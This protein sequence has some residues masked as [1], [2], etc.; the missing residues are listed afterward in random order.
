MCHPVVYPLKDDSRRKSLSFGLMLSCFRYKISCWKRMN[1]RVECFTFGNDR[2][3]KKATTTSLNF[4]IEA[5]KLE[6]SRKVWNPT[7]SVRGGQVHI[8]TS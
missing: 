1:P 8:S 6:H 5:V 7:A 3:G 2:G 4:D